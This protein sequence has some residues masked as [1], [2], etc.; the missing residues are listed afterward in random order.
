MELLYTNYRQLG[1]L[2]LNRMTI[3]LQ[4]DKWCNESLQDNRTIVN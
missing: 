3:A 4:H 1:L 2:S